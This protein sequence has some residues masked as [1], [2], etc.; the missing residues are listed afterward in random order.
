VREV[1]SV[2]R[3]EVR[4]YLVSPIPYVFTMIF[5][6]FMS[7]WFFSHREFFLYRTASME[8]FFK[9]V[10][11]AF[12]F[13]VPAITMRL[14]SEEVRGGTLE[15]LLT[16]PVRS[17]QLVGGKFLAAWTL[18]FACLVLTAPVA[19]TV[20]TLGNLDWG[21]VVG[22][23]LGTLFLGGAL[24]ALGMWVSSLTAHQIVAFLIT[25]VAA[26]F[27]VILQGLASDVGGAAGRFLDKLSVA[28]RFE[29]M[30]RG[31]I[32]LRDLVYF[33]TFMGFFLY[34]NARSVENR[35]FA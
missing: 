18:L 14:W 11:W 22:A 6:A 7:W 30:G 17:W 23:Y 27:L 13:L 12:I 9:V 29:A 19:I 3:K 34:L 15:M 24:L 25:A 10:P 26:F 28:S 8:Q 21:P 35:R 20:S 2:Y 33:L 4:A 32:D 31:V 1:L 16:L 5:T